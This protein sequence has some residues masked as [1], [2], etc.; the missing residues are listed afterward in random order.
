MNAPAGLISP[1]GMD[2][3]VCYGTA[4]DIWIQELG[5]QGMEYRTLG[6]T[7]LKVSRLSLGAMTFGGQVSEEE[8]LRMVDRCL[9]HG[10]NF[11]D[12]ANV[13]NQG[14]SEMI[15]G[16]ALR[17]RRHQVVLATKVRGKTG[18]EPED[19]GLKRPAIRRAIDESLRRLGTD[20][21]DLYYLHQPDWDTRIEE[22]LATLEDLVREGKIRYPAVSN[23]AAWQIVQMLWYCDNHGCLPPAAAQPMYNLLAR[24]IERE[25]LAFCKEYGIAVVA[26]SPLA[27]GLLTGK[28]MPG[29][30]P[31]A[32]T[33]SGGNRMHPEQYWHNAFLDA[34]GEVAVIARRAG[35][36]MLELAFRWLLTQPAVDCV[37]LGASSTSQ[38]EENLKACQGSVL[39]PAILEE[40][41]AVWEKLCSPT[42]RYDR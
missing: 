13:Y 38:L 12:T 30:P 39:E 23:Y 20:Y 8:A 31:A 35:L 27:G 4:E 25:Y 6:K 22:T 41:D 32:G 29:V 33:R 15:L 28:H 17:G 7:D 3:V 9:E 1:A 19:V 2:V 36:K 16:K 42:P 21:V 40:C 18:E 37:L 34:Q 10:I 14:K 11:Y 24:D 5:M 26:C